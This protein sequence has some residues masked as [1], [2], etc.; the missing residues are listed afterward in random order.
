MS[1]LSDTKIP[2]KEFL[3]AYRRQPCLYNTLLDSY[4]NR[5]S[6][7]E[8]YGAII[9]SL[10]IPQLTVVD[11]KLKIKSVRT[12][13][14]KELRI[15]MREKELGRCYEPKLFWFK[16][17]DSFLRSVSLSHCKR[18]GKNNPSAQST[19]LKSQTS[20]LLCTAA[21]DITMS[22]D[23]LEEEDAEVNG[24]PEECPSEQSRPTASI[25]KD[26]SS[27]CLADQSQEEHHPQRLN[28]SQQLPL[29]PVKRKS[30][31][32]TS[33]DSAGDDDLII[34]GQSIASQLRTIPDSYSRSVA[35]LRIQQVLFEAETGQFQGT[36]VN[37]TQLQ[38]TY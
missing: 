35:K 18:Q 37:S 21:A 29:P 5:V 24:E 10:K 12:V 27:L 4:K 25:C 14:S 22:E 3:E 15:W 23:A 9:R 17:A 11:I 16:L 19:P 32:T 6:R 38:H 8:A 7:E 13:Y 36:E 30:K 26:D 1:K 33:L 2:I 20:T 34:F 31:Y 28:S